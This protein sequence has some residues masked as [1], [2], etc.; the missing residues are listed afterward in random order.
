MKSNNEIR[1]GLE[2]LEDRMALN[3]AFSGAIDA[4][5]PFP[6]NALSATL[7]NIGQ[8]ST[9]F[10]TNTSGQ[11]QS[12]QSQLQALQA[13]QTAMIDQFFSEMQSLFQLL[14]VHTYIIL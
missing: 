5:A 6:M 10:S 8:A 11:T 9:G 13:A 7:S 12:L 4:G 14:N 1:L 2:V 3:G